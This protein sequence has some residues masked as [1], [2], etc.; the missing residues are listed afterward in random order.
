MVST[1]CLDHPFRLSF[2]PHAHVRCD[3][4]RWFGEEWSRCVSEQTCLASVLNRFYLIARLVRSHFRSKSAPSIAQIG[5][6]S[7]AKLGKYPLAVGDSL[8]SIIIESVAIHL[9]HI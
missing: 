2:A 8:L 7:S 9:A 6:L 4:F 1:L 3:A 5:L